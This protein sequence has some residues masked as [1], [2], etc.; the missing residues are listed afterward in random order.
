MISILQIISIVAS[1][2][3]GGGLLIF[4][5]NRQERAKRLL[6]EAE[7]SRQFAKKEIDSERRE[8]T[9]KLKDE[10]HKRRVQFE[11]E[12]HQER[13]EHERAQ[14]RVE[15]RSEELKS[16]K[17]ECDNTYRDLQEKER[18]L[19]R[20][21]DELR[22]NEE[23]FKKVY[24]DLIA[25]LERVSNM[26]QE[27]ARRQIVE[28]LESEVR[29]TQ[30]KWINKVEEE[31][32]A[33][34]KEKS[35][36]VV[37]DAMQRYTAEQVTPHSSSVVQLPN[38]D[39]KGRIIGKEGRNIKALE[40]ATG[41][42]F[43]IGD[44]PELITI[45]GFN[46]IRREVARRSLE[47]LIV[48]GRI[49]PTRIEET[50][51]NV[52]KEIDDIIEEKG[53]DAIMQVNLHGVSSDMVKTLGKLHFRTSYAQNVLAHSIEVA[54]L[55]RTIAYELGL[56]NPDLAARAGLFHDIGKA[57]SA[58]YEGPHALVGADLAKRCGESKL[59]VNGIAAHHEEVP[60]ISMYDPIIIIADTISASRP[61]ARRE[62]LAA[63]IKRLEQLEEI[64]TSFKGV[65]KAYA[66][67]AGREIRIL[68]QENALNDEDAR[69]VARQ[70][71]EKIESTM[72]FPGQIKANV[73]RETRSI[74]Y[75]R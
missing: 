17:Q 10:L 41:M 11:N 14:R 42:E 57:M 22:M 8:S 55:A 30:E 68:I 21:A 13:K 18:T 58:E 45:A 3:G 47:K 28:T 15:K 61:G 70:V 52:E 20:S 65:K 12:M 36:K 2:G 35:I 27:E 53:K 6:Q 63:Y 73:I 51:T 7:H 71:A 46:P 19:A 44:T 23:K 24:S 38:D 64:A 40:M 72:S 62:T 50:V 49:N 9:L 43:I 4:A 31:A 26:T 69:V 56:D 66:L 48:D 32:K 33:K 25:K 5:Y 75:A 59:V 74:E 34:A 39:M 29:H 60:F 54:L 37:V 1:V 16:K 67:Q